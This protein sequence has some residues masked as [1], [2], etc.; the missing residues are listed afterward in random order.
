[1][2]LFPPAAFRLNGPGREQALDAGWVSRELVY[3][4]ECEIR[5]PPG[6]LGVSPR[7]VR[8]GG[9]QCFCCAVGQQAQSLDGPGGQVYGGGGPRRGSLRQLR[10]IAGREVRQIGAPER[11]F[12]QK[13]CWFIF[14]RS[15]AGRQG[16]EL[17]LEVF[18]Q[19]PDYLELQRI[20]GFEVQAASI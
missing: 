13:T 19:V 10:E 5:P 2:N 20:A 6:S 1:M 17:V 9:V 4:M 16:L 18:R 14:L 12:H 7:V 8:E 3:L 15:G 11:R